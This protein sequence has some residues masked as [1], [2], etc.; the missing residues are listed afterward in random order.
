MLDIAD[1]RG[2]SIEDALEVTSKYE[3]ELRLI[4]YQR[5]SAEDHLSNVGALIANT[6]YNC[7]ASKK[8]K[9]LTFE[10]FRIDYDRVSMTDEEK[11]LDDFDRFEKANPNLFKVN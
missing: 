1:S 4:K 9:K 10:D 2:I 11:M 3:F 8:S 7:N 6:I 5:P